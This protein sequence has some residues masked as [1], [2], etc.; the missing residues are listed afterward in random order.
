MLN[1]STVRDYFCHTSQQTE[2]SPGSH[3]FH[4]EF[5]RWLAEVERAASEKAWVDGAHAQWRLGQERR[6]DAIPANPYRRNEG[7]NE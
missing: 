5:D 2:N 6:L 1:T 7:E 4:L 3:E